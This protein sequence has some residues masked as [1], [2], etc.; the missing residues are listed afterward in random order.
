MMII[1]YVKLM[2]ILCNNNNV[3]KKKIELI[4]PTA[5]F[6]MVS[7]SDQVYCNK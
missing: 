4:D 1:K 5:E 7:D 3:V 2:S 6:V